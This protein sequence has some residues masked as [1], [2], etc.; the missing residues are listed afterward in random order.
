[1][2]LR[3]MILATH[4]QPWSESHKMGNSRNPQFTSYKFYAVL[5]G[6]VKSQAVPLCL[7]WKELSLCPACPCCMH[8]TPVRHGVAPQGSGQLRC[9]VLQRLCSRDPISLTDSP[10]V[11]EQWCWQFRYA[12]EKPWSASAGKVN[13]YIYIL[14]IYIVCRVWYYLW[15][16]AFTG[17]LG[18]YPCG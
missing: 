12:K 9:T 3:S 1:M 17:G 14:K 8:A 18:M 11:Q 10:K 13:I 6:V 16:Q 2:V 15:F 7:T 4:C 5:S